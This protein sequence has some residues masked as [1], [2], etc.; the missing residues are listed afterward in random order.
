M[1]N[2][3]LQPH[4]DAR[5]MND[6]H[7]DRQRARTPQGALDQRDNHLG[8]GAA[9]RRKS[10]SSS[11]R[12]VRRRTRQP[13]SRVIDATESSRCQGL[14]RSPAASSSAP[15]RLRRRPGGSA[16]RRGRGVPLP[17]SRLT[18]TIPLAMIPARGSGS[19]R[20]S[21][22]APRRPVRQPWFRP[23]RE[24]RPGPERRQARCGDGRPYRPQPAPPQPRGERTGPGCGRVGSVDYQVPFLP[25]TC[26]QPPFGLVFWSRSRSRS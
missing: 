23:A 2:H 1:P 20:A 14:S 3:H 17:P 7:V 6:R 13:D 11:A 26:S 12:R 8:Y 4:L 21:R 16:A 18:A 19:A 24:A 9:R 22:A 10:R 15:L 5:L 25:V